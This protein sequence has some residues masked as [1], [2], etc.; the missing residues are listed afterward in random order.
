MSTISRDDILKLAQLARLELSDAEVTE[1]SKELTEIV[2]YVEQ[3]NSVDVTGLKPTFYGSSQTNVYRE[4]I[5]KDYG[6]ATEELRKNVP[7]VESDHIK[8]RRM[9]G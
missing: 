8:V 3:L 9:I 2:E 1:Y 4:D 5:I 6:Y 7:S